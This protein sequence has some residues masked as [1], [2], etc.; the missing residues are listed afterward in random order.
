MSLVESGAYGRAIPVLTNAAA[1]ARADDPVRPPGTDPTVTA[2]YLLK[3]ATYAGRPELT[4]DSASRLLAAPSEQ[5]FAGRLQLDAVIGA[6]FYAISTHDQRL[7]T[8]SQKVS[9]AQEVS[10]DPDL[11][12]CLQLGCYVFPER[13]RCCPFASPLRDAAEQTVP[14]SFH[15]DPLP[16]NDEEIQLIR[17]H[18]EADESGKEDLYSIVDEDLCTH[19][20]A[21]YLARTNPVPDKAKLAVARCFA[22]ARDWKGAVGLAHEYVQVFSNDWRGWAIMV[23]PATRRR[24]TARLTQLSARRLA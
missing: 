13:G 1:R 5:Y 24:P 8:K 14:L 4:G 17:R 6:D 20:G 18:I 2:A 12:M 19:L 15:E 10:N 21:Y 9:L 23:R 3:A 16:I 22:R 11:R 7:F